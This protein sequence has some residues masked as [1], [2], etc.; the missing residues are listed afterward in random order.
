MQSRTH[1]LT[2]LAVVLV[3]G[4]VS[5]CGHIDAEPITP[6]PRPTANFSNIGYADWSDDE[7]S[8]RFYPGDEVEVTVPSAS[9]STRP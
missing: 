7:P 5:A 3:A 2:A 8:Y 4:G 6:G 9:N 1:F